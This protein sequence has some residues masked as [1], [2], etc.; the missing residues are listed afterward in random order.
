MKKRNSLS[1]KIRFEVFK[2]DGFVCQYCGANP[3]N[4]VL[5]VDHINPVCNGGDDVIDNLI[6]ACFNC[7]RGKA[8]NSLD[9][10]PQSLSDKA[11]EV[12]ER[13]LQIAG[14]NKVLQDKADR[15]Y[16]QSWDVVNVLF[17]SKERIRNDW[18]SS[19]KTFINRL[20]FQEVI[21]AAEIA[22]SKPFHSET[23]IFLYFCGVC[24]RKIKEGEDGTR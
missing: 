20:P 9:S 24:W 11:K 6:T 12:Q 10:I 5:E 21:D 4:V 17:P 16:E 1:K 7:N 2:R 15:I 23:K 13:E 8:G 14:Y 19:I 22:N 18:F 3:P